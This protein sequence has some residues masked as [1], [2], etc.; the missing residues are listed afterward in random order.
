[1]LVYYKIYSKMG[2]GGRLQGIKNGLRGPLEMFG[3]YAYLAIAD[4]VPFPLNLNP[5]VT[6]DPAFASNPEA[7]FA[8]VA[9]PTPFWGCDEWPVTELDFHRVFNSPW[10]MAH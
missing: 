6:N 4:G 10:P 3:D 8:K 7:V 9:W 1:L 5:D 2:I